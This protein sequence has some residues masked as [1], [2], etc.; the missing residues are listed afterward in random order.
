[1]KKRFK[2]HVAE[3]PIEETSEQFRN[4]L[5]F[6]L[7]LTA[8]F[9]INFISRIV[10]A[11]L[12]PTIESDL[13]INHTEAGSLF[14]FIS[15]GYFISLLGS[16]FFSSRF[17]HRQT[18]VFSGIAMGFALFGASVSHGLWAIRTTL[19]FLGLAAGLYLPSGIAVITT[20]FDM[21]HW[22]KA[23]AI[24]EMAPN[25]SFVVAPL[26]A[27]A[28][29]LRFNWRGVFVILGFGSIAL[30]ALFVRYGLGGR[31]HGESPSISSIKGIIFNSSFWVMVFLFGLGISGTLGV[32]TMLPVF[33]VSTHGFE[34]GMANTLIAGS[35]VAGM[36][37][38]FLG[39]WLTD[40]IGAKKILMIVF[41][42]NGA[43]T[44]LIGMASSA[45]VVLPVVLQPII[46]ACFFPAGLAALSMMSRPELRNL[47]VSLTV[48][49]AFLVGGGMV[50]TLIG[51]IGDVSSFSI[52]I[53]IVG[54]LILTGAGFSMLIEDRK[55]F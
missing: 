19:F 18:I 49:I 33:L 50:P 26:L 10:L 16:G 53:S 14:L 11:P 6:V 40:R 20:T 38:T 24:H 31:F 5:G 28:V 45:L 4:R 55:R 47:V 42:V 2:S 27:E 35:R 44:V 25:L 41:L 46:A 29:M 43:A 36:V 13:G 39:G 51:Y 37:M 54:G 1:M 48:P 34:R 23:I 9:F 17:T 12:I 32:F 22:G 15:C 52:G 30:A 8:V 3:R 7:L 21:R